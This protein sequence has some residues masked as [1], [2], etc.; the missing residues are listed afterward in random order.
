MAQPIWNTTA[1][2]LGSFPYGVAISYQLSASAVAP[3]TSVTYKLQSGSLPNGLTLSSS[4]L[5]SGIPTS[6]SDPTN[7]IFV[8]RVT[9]NFSAITDR[10]F[11][12]N[13]SGY[14]SPSFTITSGLIFSSLDSRWVEFPIT[15]NNPSNVDLTV[16]VED[17]SLPE[18]LEINSNGLIRGYPVK[19]T[20]TETT[21][22]VT[23]LV[24]NTN[25]NNEITCVSTNE[26]FVGRPITFV[27]TTFGGITTSTT[28]YV[29][30]ILSTTQF[31][32]SLSQF[33]PEVTLSSASGLMSANLPAT[34]NGLPVLRT[35]NFTLSLNVGNNS[36]QV[37]DYR[38]RIANQN[39]PASEGGLGTGP[40][41]RIPTLLNTRPLS[42]VIPPDSVLSEYTLVPASGVTYS[43]STNVS[44]GTIKSGDFF[45]FKFIG[46]DFDSNDFTYLFSE[47]PSWLTGDTTTGWL[48][49][50]LTLGSTG[51]SEFTFR[52]A[53]AKLANPSIISTYFNFQVKV[54]SEIIGDIEWIT[55]ND[56][57]QINNNTIS[58]LKVVAESDTP[59]TYQ[60]TSGSL[61]PNLTLSSDGE[62]FGKVAYQPLSFSLSQG[63]QTT[64][65]FTI[66]AYSVDYPIINSSRTFTLTVYQYFQQPTDI[67]YMK[68]TPSLS[69]RQ[70]L[71]TLL[72]NTNLIPNDFIYRPDD[73]YFGKASA[74]IYQHAY[75]INASNID[76]Y[77]AAIT[78]N[79]YW[80][81]ITLGELKTA[82]AKNA[83]GETIYEVVYSEIID[84]L[85][86]NN[87]LSVSEEIT[88]P[89][90]IN[91]NLGP[92][93]TSVTN[94]YTSYENVLG[95]EYYTSLSSGVA[96][97]LYP[98]SL[99]NMS[100][101]VGQVLGSSGDSNLLPLWMTSQQ[102]NGSTLGFTKAWVICY[103]KPGFSNVV[104]NTINSNWEYKLNQI[105]FEIDRFTVDKSK[106]YNY[107]TNIVFSSLPNP[108]T[109]NYTIT[110]V[111][112][113]QASP[114]GINPLVTVTL[115]DGSVW[116]V[117]HLT[118]SWTSYPSATPVPN[119][120]DSEDFYVIF[121]QKTI[122]PNESQ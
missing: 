74:V 94:I 23:T 22:A 82:V 103:T 38:I 102:P 37:I 85:V 111:D 114:V 108:Y 100:T 76:Q 115:T 56:L 84:D 28:Y 15:Y 8:V 121:E 58:T 17:G 24:T 65:T 80:R 104:K 87:N 98:N 89:R 5:I 1:G 53:V 42:F 64:F 3:A 93:Y 10:T 29:K 25:S 119:P 99:F 66:Q 43:P 18:G 63:D 26:F 92:W 34:Y 46:Y 35:Y 79:H 71:Q 90:D 77:L 30:E 95:Q 81:N 96:R 88:W 109:S 59:L 73:I 21:N 107:T 62:I 55:P 36:V 106:T 78:K 116:R 27:G 20:I 41:Q 6:V 4:G 40:N 9:D 75:G 101:R 54:Y 49:G 44:L 113:T 97:Y 68:A 2:S 83:E 48:S 69:D 112:N 52:V 16:K 70:K 39:L 12:I 117:T 13:I 60:I 122:L 47:L 105:N 61:P 72:T 120:I 32:I 91:L 33:G 7:Y 57:G 86:N 51:V 31:K 19:P 110:G 50:S 67:L 118:N 11:I 14:I 45:S